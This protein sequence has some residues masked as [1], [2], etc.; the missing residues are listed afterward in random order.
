MI[1]FNFLTKLIQIN[2]VCVV[3]ESCPLAD[4]AATAIANRVHSKSDIRKAIDI[5]KT[6]DGA[7][8]LVVIVD[9]EID[10]WGDLKVVPLNIKKG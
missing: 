6:I 7:G 8:G 10:I 9:D 4:A 1:F 2:A 3:S 5:G